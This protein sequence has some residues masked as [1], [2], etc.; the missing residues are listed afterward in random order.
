[1]KR[2]VKY[3]LELVRESS[4][5]YEKKT[6]RSPQDAYDIATDVLGLMKRPEEELWVFS[7]NTKNDVT[8]ML[9]VSRGSLSSS[10]VHPREVFKG[11]L[12]NNAASIIAIH[13][14]PSGNATPS[15]EDIEVTKRLT[16]AGKI[17]GVELL[18][19]IVI[20]EGEYVSLKEKGYV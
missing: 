19:H 2:L 14:H 7:L 1:M 5:L 17:L 3:T 8:G 16:E 15:R 11:A 18:D 13:Q 10:I 20:G 6:I 9:M 12:L 4:Y